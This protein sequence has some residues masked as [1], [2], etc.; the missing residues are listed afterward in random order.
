MYLFKFQFKPHFLKRETISQIASPYGSHM[1]ASMG[2][3]IMGSPCG[4]CNRDSYV[5]DMGCSYQALWAAY[6]YPI[7][8]PH[9]QLIWVPYG[10][11]MRVIRGEY[12][13]DS[14]ESHM[15][16]PLVAHMGSSQFHT[17]Q[18]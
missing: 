1:G 7:R 10:M 16:S 15:G 12:N 9:R 14:Y 4:E 13:R 5:S 11:P 8:D 3:F 17:L 2:H 6:L 18:I